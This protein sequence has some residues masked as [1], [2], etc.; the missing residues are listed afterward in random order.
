METTIDGK[1]T[2]KRTRAKERGSIRV[3]PPISRPEAT[4]TKPKPSPATAAS[5]LRAAAWLG[6]RGG[7][8]GAGPQTVHGAADHRPDPAVDEP[9]P[10][11]GC[12][13][14]AAR[15]HPCRYRDVD[16][17][18]EPAHRSAHPVLRAARPIGAADRAPAG[19]G[20]HPDDH[21]ARADSRYRAAVAGLHSRAA[22]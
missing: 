15:H 14:P 9:A 6:T 17:D 10:G 21:D 20:S 11:P 5:S 7:R 22:G 12:C 2:S 8:P 16:H 19:S 18:G 1:P 13:V 3:H 4:G